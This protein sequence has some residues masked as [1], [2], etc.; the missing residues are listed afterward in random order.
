MARKLERAATAFDTRGAK[1]AFSMDQ[2]L[3]QELAE[4]RAAV[5]RAELSKYAKRLDTMA[6]I[7]AV[8]L[9]VPKPLV[10]LM[11]ALV[12][13]FERVFERP[14]ATNWRTQPN[15]HIDIAAGPFLSFASAYLR[16]VGC[17]HTA[18]TIH[19]DLYRYRASTRRQAQRS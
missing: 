17:P 18:T 2:R 16:E 7:A 3:A 8:Q 10:A 15:S 12:E 4:C 9:K 5:E 1:R 14:A 6:D 19:T 11:P 13:C